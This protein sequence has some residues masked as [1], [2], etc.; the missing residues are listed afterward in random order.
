M[1]NLRSFTVA[2]LKAAP[3]GITASHCGHAF[4]FTET[5][6]G[7]CWTNYAMKAPC[8]HVYRDNSL[9]YLKSCARTWAGAYAEDAGLRADVAAI[10]AGG[11]DDG[12]GAYA[13]MH[14]ICTNA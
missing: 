3:E 2:D 6:N 1:Q 11:A 4:E 10:Q 9:S 8:G 12:E 5:R 14:R 13:P 7:E